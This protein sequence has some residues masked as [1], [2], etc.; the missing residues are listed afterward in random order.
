M[1]QL[2]QT[3]HPETVVPGKKRRDCRLVGGLPRT[4]VHRTNLTAT[5]K[6]PIE[7]PLLRKEPR[8]RQ[9]REHDGVD[10]PGPLA[11]MAVVTVTD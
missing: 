6:R 7:L 4:N 1:D 8:Y 11:S 5:E 9:L 2:T 10:R 3:R